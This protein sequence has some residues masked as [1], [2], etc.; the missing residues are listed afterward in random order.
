[1]FVTVSETILLNIHLS[2]M[3]PRLEIAW[4]YC[5]AVLAVSFY[6]INIII[7]LI[8]LLLLLLLLLLVAQTSG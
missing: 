7:P 4:V 3:S 1:L 8:E 5:V 2:L 6:D